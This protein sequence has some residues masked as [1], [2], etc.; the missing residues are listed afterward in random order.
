ME[1]TWFDE[2]DKT[3]I[4]SLYKTN[5]TL[6]C[7]ASEPFQSAY[8][9]RVGGDKNGN[10]IVMPLDKDQVERDFTGGKGIYKIAVKQSYSRLSSTQLMSQIGAML[11][12]TLSDKP[13][14]FP[15]YFDKREGVLVITTGKENK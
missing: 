9:V 4:A 13:V 3:G 5:M 1:I 2:K 8:R 7:V 15:T 6:N 12:L 14:Q 10:I 11:G